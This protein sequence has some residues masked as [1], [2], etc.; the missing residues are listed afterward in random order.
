MT[1][2][3]DL[4][5]T[6]KLIIFLCLVM[7]LYIIYQDYNITKKKKNTHNYL[8]LTQEIQLGYNKYK[9]TSIMPPYIVR[10]ENTK[11]FKILNILG[12]ISFF[13]III[14]YKEYINISF[15]LSLLIKIF[16]LVYLFFKSIWIFLKLY[17]EIHQ[18]YQSGLIVR[19][20]RVRYISTL[21]NTAAHGISLG[22]KIFGVL[23]GTLGLTG[24]SLSIDAAAEDFGMPKFHLARKLASPILDR[25][26]SEDWLQIKNSN[27]VSSEEADVKRAWMKYLEAPNES[28]KKERLR[29]FIKV[30]MNSIS[31][32]NNSYN[33][34]V[35]KYP[36]VLLGNSV[37]DFI[38]HNNGEDII[39]KIIEQELYDNINRLNINNPLDVIKIESLYE[40]K[41]NA[42]NLIHL[43]LESAHE[44][45]ISNTNKVNNLNSYNYGSDS[46]HIINE[47]KNSKEDYNFKLELNK[48]IGI[49]YN[50]ISH[51]FLEVKKK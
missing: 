47:W 39:N 51:K 46:T 41:K 3:L 43:Q 23:M 38:A 12:L 17:Y 48:L 29:Y 33:S 11:V 42:I 45:Y 5:T 8:S 6:L 24:V 18:I 21:T 28:I 26:L 20:S 15:P 10:L 7:C 44:V 19:N 34:L 40:E 14:I 31:E 36:N 4:S 27:I 35:K 30:K 1:Q 2:V 49:E 25:V 16:A 22:K 37:D 13:I 32:I 9:A 50:I